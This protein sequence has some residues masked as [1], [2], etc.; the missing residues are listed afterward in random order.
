M[1]KGEGGS[2]FSHGMWKR[3]GFKEMVKKHNPSQPTDI[4]IYI[5]K[6]PTTSLTPRLAPYTKPF[7]SPQPFPAPTPSPPPPNKCKPHPTP[8]PQRQNRSKKEKD[9]PRQQNTQENTR[10][11]YST[12][13]LTHQLTVMAPPPP[14]PGKAGIPFLAPLLHHRRIYNILFV[15]KGG[16]G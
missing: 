15:C 3:L 10:Q 1:K 4:Y 7:P 6:P 14:P 16:W 11:T 2:I 8:P 13:S 9:R 5:K 12:C